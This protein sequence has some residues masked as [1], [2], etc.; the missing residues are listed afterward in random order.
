MKI[1]VTGG[2]G[3]IGSNLVDKLIELENYVVSVD[4]LN[5]F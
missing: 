5:D 2:A 1:L 3:F 4:N